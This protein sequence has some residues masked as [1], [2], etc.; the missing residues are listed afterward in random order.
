MGLGKYRNEPCP[1]GSGIKFKHCHLKKLGEAKAK[2]MIE[3]ADR[4]NQS[5]RKVLLSV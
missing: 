3:R 2:E 1:C 4:G 5:K